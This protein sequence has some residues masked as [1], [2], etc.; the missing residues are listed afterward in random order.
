MTER[1]RDFARQLRQ[2]QTAAEEKAWSLLRNN[3]I[4]GL[5][6]RRQHVVEGFVVDFYCPRL[7]LAIELDG[8]VHDRKMNKDY[9]ELRQIELESKG[10][11]VLRFRNEQ[12]MQDEKIIEKKILALA[13][14]ERAVKRKLMKNENRVRAVPVP[15]GEG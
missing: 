3:Q 10:V 14:W 15:G 7:K 11:A 5:K 6:F 4:G 8:G 13:P 1:K 12:V 2:D 9:D